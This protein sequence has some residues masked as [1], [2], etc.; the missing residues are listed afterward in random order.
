MLAQLGGDPDDHDAEP[1]AARHRGPLE[2]LDP[3]RAVGRRAVGRRAVG[4]GEGGRNREPGCAQQG[5]QSSHGN[6]SF[7]AAA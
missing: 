6:A 1:A 5:K 2:G 3:W 7:R 4:H